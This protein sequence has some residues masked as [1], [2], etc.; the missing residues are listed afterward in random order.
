MS[1]CRSLACCSSTRSLR[2]RVRTV[3]GW[4]YLPAVSVRD[5][6]DGATSCTMTSPRATRLMKLTSV[7]GRRTLVARAGDRR[8][9]LARVH[10]PR[11]S[12]PPQSDV[13]KVLVIHCSSY[14]IP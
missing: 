2:R 7:K 9:A 13:T 6:L 14:A 4:S 1:L 11:P 10:L 5:G 12:G 3:T 8:S